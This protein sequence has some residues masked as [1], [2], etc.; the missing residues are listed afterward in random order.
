MLSYASESVHKGQI[1]ETLTLTKKS[2]T[3]GENSE[4]TKEISREVEPT[5]MVDDY[6]SETQSTDKIITTEVSIY[7]N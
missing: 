7:L 4:D 5:L 1:E 6:V 3:T 2:E